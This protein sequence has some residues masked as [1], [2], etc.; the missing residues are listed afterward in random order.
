MRI[1]L[2]L[3]IFSDDRTCGSVSHKDYPLTQMLRLQKIS[4]YILQE[5]KLAIFILIRAAEVISFKLHFILQNGP[6]CP[7]GRDSQ[8]GAFC[9]RDP[10]LARGARVCALLVR[11]VP[12]LSERVPGLSTGRLLQPRV[13]GPGQGGAPGGVHRHG[14]QGRRPQRSAEVRHHNLISIGLFLRGICQL[15]TSIHII[16]YWFAWW[17]W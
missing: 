16:N 10:L 2:W 13:S 14:Q 3:Y 7:R 12:G 6:V 4:S 1:R 9:A 17:W 15:G 5:P 8:I 11:A